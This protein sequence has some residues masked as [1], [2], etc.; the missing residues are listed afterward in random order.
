MKPILLFLGLLLLTLNSFST[1]SEI[2]RSLT[3]GQSDYT[4]QQKH[5]VHHTH[6]S[7]NKHYYK[8]VDGARVQSPTQYD[9]IPAGACAVCGDGSYSFSRNH[10]GDC[11]HHGGVK[12]WLN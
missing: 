3:F 1:T 4:A 8:N 9:V 11:S 12:K 10:R 7:G 5:S 6:V 2:G